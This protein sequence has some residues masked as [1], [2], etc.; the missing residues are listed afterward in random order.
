MKV[1]ISSKVSSS[2]ALRS[3]PCASR[4]AFT[5]I[6][7]LTVVMIMAAFMAV[8]GFGLHN[9]WRSQQIAASASMLEQEFALAKTLAI[10]RNQPVELRLYK[11]KD[12]YQTN[13]EGQYRAF[14]IV[15]ISPTG[16]GFGGLLTEVRRFESTVVMVPFEKFSSVIALEQ[17]L[18]A[19]QQGATDSDYK[20]IGIEIR[21]DGSTSLDPDPEKP[22]TITLVPD[23]FAED[24]TTLPKDFRTLVINPDTVEVTIH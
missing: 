20:Y 10:K 5:I 22:W 19:G 11:T 8:A 2:R 3:A 12:E 4:P 14:H 21:P 9:S 15:S 7:M 23:V 16:V 13:A 17:T 6:E 18:E 24:Q 1:L